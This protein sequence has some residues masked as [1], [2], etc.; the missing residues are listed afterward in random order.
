MRKALTFFFF[1]LAVSV[2]RAQLFPLIQ[3]IHS[4]PTQTLDGRWQIIIDPLE[5]GYY[6][7]RYQVSNNGFFK[8]A[9]MQQPTDLIEYNF[10]EGEELQVPGDW[11]TQLEKLYYYEGTIWYKRDFD[12]SVNPEK[13]VFVYFGA[14]NY[15]AKVYLNGEKIGEHIGGYTPFNIELTGKLREKDNFLVV[16]VDNTRKR[17]A[18]PTVNTDWWN[19]GGITRSVYLFE[20]PQTFIQDYSVQLKQGSQDEVAGW[21]QLSN[22]EGG[23][24]HFGIPE[25]K[26]NLDLRVNDSGRAEFSFKRKMNLWSTSNPKRYAIEIKAGDDLIKDQIGFRSITTSG[27]QILLNG[28]PIFLKGISVHEESPFHAGRVTT[29]SECEVLVR[30]AKE[31][32]CNFLRL[33]H[34]PHSEEMVQVA[35]ENGLLIWS[36]IPVYWTVLFDNKET[37]QNAENQ[38]TEM[39]TRD[40]NRAAIVLWSVANETPVSDARVQFLSS[41]ASKA[42]SLDPTR[43]ITAAMDTH[44]SVD[45]FRVID[46]PL[47]QYLDVVGVNQYC[48][49][50]GG[51]VDECGEVRWKITQDKPLII[52]EFGGGALQGLHGAANERWT[53]EYQ[54][55][56][57][58]Y[59]IEMLRHIDFLAGTSPWILKDFLSPRRNLDRIQNDFNRK[60]LISEKGVKKMAFFRLKAFYEEK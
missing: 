57:Y 53:E 42:K 26:V 12:Y 3:N 54:D 29:R 14:V 38:L 30:W 60:G 4:R 24:V 10:D 1:I 15:D 55:E 36:E 45:G 59:N 39:I 20:T 21:I 37:Y 48:G 44:S 17:E 22:A 40:N 2:V 56:V 58:K 13:R 43:L 35:E 11:N 9:K 27:H 8:N 6:T 50:Y 16:K 51:K 32:G 23:I 18:I 46:D 25:L 34:Y 49:W 31:L 7:H 47:M 33:A 41:L 19:Y 52:S 5:N 28:K